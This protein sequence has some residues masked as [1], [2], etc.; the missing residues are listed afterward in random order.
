MWTGQR[1]E[2]SSSGAWRDSSSADAC[3]GWRLFAGHKCSC[4]EEPTGSLVCSE[5]SIG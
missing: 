2:R 3:V 5:I 4:L 1:G